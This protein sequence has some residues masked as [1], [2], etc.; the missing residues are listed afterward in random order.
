MRASC[1]R[2]VIYPRRAAILFALCTGFVTIAQAQTLVQTRPLRIAL[3]PFEDRA[4]FQGKFDLALDVPSLLGQYLSASDQ[5]EIV[6]M[7][8]VEAAV[9]EKKELKKLDVRG[10]VNIGRHLGADVVIVGTVDK[11]N[12]RR[13]TA[14]APNLLTYRSYSA[15]ISLLD[16]G[17]IKVATEREV[18]TIDL[19]RE[20]VERPLGLDLFGRPRQQDL[21]FRELFDVD[22]G[23]ERFFE[24]PLGKL[25]AD[26]FQELGVQIIATLMERRPIDL[27]GETARVLSVA[28]E[29]VF[30]GV[31]SLDHVEHRDVVP[32]YE[33]GGAQI[34]LVEVDEILGSHLCRARIIEQSG[35]VVAGFD[36]GQRVSEMGHPS[37]KE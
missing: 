11:F 8:T 12:M 7:D 15:E 29:E 30:L 9:P 36:I 17:L 22:F 20:S 5:V 13:A 2:L 26:A 21:E 35:P 34:A 14:G 6:P 3:L 37:E 10:L 23:S 4:G 32:V 33:K 25:T 31:G 1:G 27:S 28:D 18:D 19:S 16:V 24:L